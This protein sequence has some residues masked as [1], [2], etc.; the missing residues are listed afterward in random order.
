MVSDEHELRIFDLRSNS[1]S[2]QMHSQPRSL[3]LYDTDWNQ[4]YSNYQNVNKK[5]QVGFNHMFGGTSSCA[6]N[7]WTVDEYPHTKTEFVSTGVNYTKFRWSITNPTIFATSGLNVLTLWNVS[8]SIP[9][10]IIE[11]NI[12][13]R[14]NHF[15]WF[16]NEQA[17]VAATNKQ[18]IF[19]A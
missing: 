2:A 18:L 19:V 17:L 1:P 15:S 13:E 14:I 5:D 3:P 10:N 8:D 11:T 6:W 4:Y 9:L 7:T 16:R 12:P